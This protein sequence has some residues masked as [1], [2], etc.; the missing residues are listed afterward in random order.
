MPWNT[1][2][3]AC[4]MVGVPVVLIAAIYFISKRR[5]RKPKHPVEKFCDVPCHRAFFSLI[6][7]P[8]YNKHSL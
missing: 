2:I 5:T 6:L 4:L 1:L 7:P 8:C 3:A